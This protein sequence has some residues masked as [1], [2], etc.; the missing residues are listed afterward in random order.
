MQTDS[1]RIFNVLSN[2]QG[3]QAQTRMISY[4]RQL[5]GTMHMYA[6]ITKGT[7]T[8]THPHLILWSVFSLSHCINFDCVHCTL[9]T[10]LATSKPALQNRWVSFSTHTHTHTLV[11]SKDTQNLTF[12]I[13]LYSGK[14]E[15]KKSLDIH[16]SKNRM[17]HRSTQTYPSHIHVADTLSLS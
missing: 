16:K 11:Y 3:H 8:T 14:E 15:R 6:A 9:N 5:S 2:A 13:H 10:T 12:L 4:Q 7:I 17:S 1:N